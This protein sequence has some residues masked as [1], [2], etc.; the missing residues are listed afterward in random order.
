MTYAIAKQVKKAL[1]IELDIADK[2]LKE[3]DSYGKT[4]MGLTPDHVKNMESWKQAKLEFDQTFAALRNFN[5]KF[6]KEYKKEI[7]QERREKMKDL[8]K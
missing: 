6:T 1:E 2:K 4:S 7:Q 3:F 5:G 8:Q